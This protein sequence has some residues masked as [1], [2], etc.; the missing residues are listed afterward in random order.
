MK[1]VILYHPQS[2]HSR[3]V[4]EYVHE[5]VIRNPEMSIEAISVDTREG[6]TAAEVYDVVQYPSMLALR[7]SGELVKDW[8]GLPLPLMND[9][10]FF[11]LS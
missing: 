4:E 9:V 10:A 11:A 3:V 8:Q 6:A 7:E 1:I 2:D 5:F